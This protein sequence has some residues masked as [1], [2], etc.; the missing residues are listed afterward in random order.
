MIEAYPKPQV[1]QMLTTNLDFCGEEAL[2][3][4]YKWILRSPPQTTVVT[5]EMLTSTSIDFGTTGI[6]N[7]E[8]RWPNM[9]NR[10]PQHCPFAVANRYSYDNISVLH[11]LQLMWSTYKY[12]IICE[13]THT[14]L[15]F[16]TV[17]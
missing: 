4:S 10:S 9:R 7:T 12:I 15:V 3:C 5:Q 13:Y 6:S 17:I 2:K 8:V 16:S 1:E 14:L 11:F